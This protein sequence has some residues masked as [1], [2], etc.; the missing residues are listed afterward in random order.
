MT[1]KIKPEEYKMRKMT[2]KEIYNKHLEDIK[3]EWGDIKAKT[4]PKP[5]LKDCRVKFTI[6]ASNLSNIKF[7]LKDIEQE[8]KWDNP[9]AIFSMEEVK[10]TFGLFSSYYVMINNISE[11]LAN[12]LKEWHDGVMRDRELRDRELNKK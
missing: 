10:G 3:N 4:E 2:K 7:V 12:R 6:S 5:K 9:K 1:T 8:V 11:D